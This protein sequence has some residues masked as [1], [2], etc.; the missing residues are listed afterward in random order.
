M[1]TFFFYLIIRYV[2][3]QINTATNDFSRDLYEK[4]CNHIN[5]VIK[6]RKM[7]DTPRLSNDTP[8]F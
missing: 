2:H 8:D 3:W 6:L 4:K 5:Y 1:V 7:N